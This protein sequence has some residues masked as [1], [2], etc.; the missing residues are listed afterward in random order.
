MTLS[1]RSIALEGVGGAPLV[2]ALSG[3][4]A[5]SVAVIPQP[6]RLVGRV[7]ALTVATGV[8]IAMSC[9]DYG[10]ELATESLSEC[11]SSTVANADLREASEFGAELDAATAFAVTIVGCQQ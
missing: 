1:S 2:F 5:P 4:V 3:F 11:Q 9:I 10:V 6:S 8:L 7:S